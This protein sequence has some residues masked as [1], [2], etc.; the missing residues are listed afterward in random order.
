MLNAC[1][2][3]AITIHVLALSFILNSKIDFSFISYIGHVVLPVNIVITA[4]LAFITY[5]L[6]TRHAVQD[7]LTIALEKRHLFFNKVLGFLYVI[8]SILC[9][10]VSLARN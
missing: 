1:L 6:A 4:V 10:F 8:A 9:F 2:L 7:Q 3:Y 5:K